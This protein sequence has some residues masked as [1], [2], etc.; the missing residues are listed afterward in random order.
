MDRRAAAAAAKLL[1]A[2]ALPVHDSRRFPD[3]NAGLF[4][5]GSELAPADM[6]TLSSADGRA[7]AN[8]VRSLASFRA[9]A[10][11]LDGFESETKVPV[12]ADAR[13]ALELL[14]SAAIDDV[15]RTG[16]ASRFDLPARTAVDDIRAQIL[17][18]AMH[19]VCVF[20]MIA[21]AMLA[22]AGAGLILA[23]RHLTPATA[24]VTVTTQSPQR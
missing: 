6:T 16:C 23:A 17:R 21:L 14:P 19:I 5:F 12:R 2:S 10:D 11:A 22:G 24:E 7:P 18:R 3:G 20:L 1:H 9:E 15:R 8:E 4:E 13:P